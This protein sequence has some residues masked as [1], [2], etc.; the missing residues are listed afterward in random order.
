[1]AP[2]LRS[3]GRRRSYRRTV[4]TNGGPPPRP[5]RAETRRAAEDT[6]ARTTRRGLVE[7]QIVEAATELFAERGFAG[8]SL[9]DIADATG[10]TRPALYHYFSSKEDLLSRLVSE[11]TVGPAGDLRRIRRDD[12]LSLVERLRAMAAS[13]A[14]LQAQRPDRFRLLIRSEAELPSALAKTYDAGRRSVLREFT[15]VID[16]GVRSGH[17]RAVEPRVA[18]LGIIGLCNW[19][20]WWHR[21]GSDDADRQVV[22]ALADMA[23]ASVVAQDQDQASGSG[24]AQALQRLKKDVAALERLIPDE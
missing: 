17:L 2:S 22:A 4:R 14:L 18:A 21:P 9:Q 11:V 23:V 12:T 5:R 13:V 7:T 16:E 20:A 6:G 3:T 8:T 19:V 15:A 10:L 1:M 24:V